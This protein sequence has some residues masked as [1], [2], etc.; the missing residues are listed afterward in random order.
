[1]VPAIK[2]EGGRATAVRAGVAAEDD[3]AAMRPAPYR[4]DGRRSIAAT[5]IAAKI[6]ARMN[7]TSSE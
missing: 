6:T 4:R 7:P 2:A 5:M 3:V 1:V